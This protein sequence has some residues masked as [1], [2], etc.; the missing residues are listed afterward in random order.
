MTRHRIP[1]FN[2]HAIL[3][4][5]EDGDK[6]TPDHYTIHLDKES[7][8]NYVKHELSHPQNLDYK[9]IPGD[10]HEMK[11]LSYDVHRK[12]LIDKVIVIEYTNT[13]LLKSIN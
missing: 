12:L 13:S 11:L 5:E 6:K 4:T 8:E 9:I 3:W 7:A 1:A 10:P 2:V